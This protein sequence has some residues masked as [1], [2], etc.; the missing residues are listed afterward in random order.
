M[1]SVLPA[2]KLELIEKKRKREQDERQKLEGERSRQVTV[3]E[4][5]RS[6]LEKKK[7]G[8]RDSPETRDKPTGLSVNSVF[9]PRI[10][11]K[12]SE[13][14]LA[15]V[16][17]SRRPVSEVDDE[18][19]S[20]RKSSE[21]YESRNHGSPLYLS[22]VDSNSCVTKAVEIPTEVERKSNKQGSLQREVVNNR[23]S[24]QQ[25]DVRSPKEDLKVSVTSDGQF[26]TKV[27]NEH[28]KAPSVLGYKRMFE[29]SKPENKKAIGEPR[30]VKSTES[31]KADAR[32]DKRTTESKLDSANDK[33][34][35]LISNKSVRDNAQS[36]RLEE[37]TSSQSAV[38]NEL[39]TSTPPP[40]TAPKP[41]KSYVSTP[42][43]LKNAS[44]HS[45]SFQSG[46]KSVQEF[47]VANVNNDVEK[48]SKDFL[49]SDQKSVDAREFDVKDKP[50]KTL[51][52][53]YPEI[54]ASASEPEKRDQL[55]GQTVQ[56][57]SVVK[58]SDATEEQ[59]SIK[60]AKESES[61]KYVVISFFINNSHGCLI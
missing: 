54:S 13:K 22:P 15:I 9:G 27:D 40:S 10:V 58:E 6:L 59:L 29:Q 61:M 56:K 55:E 8:A 2:W 4:W 12:T 17:A 37:S 53:S 24:S 36:I 39:K 42:P 31:I 28:V 35:L 5:K 25:S 48:A 26:K 18:E 60:P 41:F 52:R 38:T 11:R 57:Y 32:S 43:W 49:K 3:P 50:K 20:R 19:N 7:E 46:K 51:N 23:E 34:Q 14:T 16:R 45:V 30:I 21:E 33:S 47:V 44:A 1:T